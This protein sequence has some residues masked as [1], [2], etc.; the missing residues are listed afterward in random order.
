[1]AKELRR[2]PVEH[3]GS[4]LPAWASCLDQAEPPWLQ[5]NARRARLAH[6]RCEMLRRTDF[7]M[8]PATS[9]PARGTGLPFQQGPAGRSKR[10]TA[11][12][13]PACTGD[14][15]L[16]IAAAELAVAAAA[17]DGAT[18]VLLPE[19]AVTPYFCDLAAGAYRERAQP[20][21]GPL[22]E[23]FAKLAKRLGI[24][25]VLPLFEHDV[26]AGT[27][28]NSAVVIG[29]DGLI[30]PATDRHGRSR[31]A[32]RK[33]HLPTADIPGSGETAHFKPGDGLGVHDVDGVR[34]G[35]LVCYDR[36][37]PECWRELRA[38]GAQLV[39]VPIAGSAGEDPDYIIGELRAH[40]GENGLFAVAASKVGT[41]WVNGVSID[42]DGES[43]V[44]AAD[45]RVLQ[46]RSG[47]AGPGLVTAD[48]DLQ[49]LGDTR[50]RLRFFDDRR[51]D[52]F[53]GPIPG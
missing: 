2:D 13:L 25:I 19:L 48:L 29:S 35:V 44:I 10:V 26:V 18:L 47:L 21:P 11:A 39:L 14:P 49:S 41:E 27:W 5:P 4:G 52:L 31:P 36:R 28:H 15:A 51:T 17:D 46:H 7:T 9:P 23:Q 50:R 16:D 40:A 30:V 53:Q 22:T 45:G 20:V 8:S 6:A 34:L 38:M 1:M 24:A 3:A 42:N 37:F 33:L 43:V 32:A 12:Q